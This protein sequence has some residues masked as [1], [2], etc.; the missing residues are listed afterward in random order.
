LANIPN[1]C[2]KSSTAI[3]FRLKGERNSS[4]TFYIKVGAE[5]NDYENSFSSDK[6][7]TY[8]LPY[9]KEKKEEPICYNDGAL[10]EIPQGPGEEV[11]S[12]PLRRVEESIQEFASSDIPGEVKTPV[13]EVTASL[14][15][16]IFHAAQNKTPIVEVLEQKLET[17]R[18]KGGVVFVG[19]PKP[20]ETGQPPDL[21]EI[22]QWKGRR[23][24][25]AALDFL[26]AHYGQWLSV[27]NSQQ[28]DAVFQDQ[29]RRHDPKLLHGLTNQ[30]LWEGQGR[31]IREFVKPRSART[32]RELASITSESLKH[33]ESLS[34]SKR[35]RQAKVR[36]APKPSSE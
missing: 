18:R 31:K 16:G 7:D 24:D 20:A 14:V 25:G 33:A 2:I 3:E 12:Q 21:S 11:K 22:P 30:L 6:Q 23:K 17:L 29:I 5:A 35:R 13:F 34:V 32:D 28:E 4:F 19:E 36:T 10:K 26:Q 9:I 1:I 15:Q 8:H 27:F